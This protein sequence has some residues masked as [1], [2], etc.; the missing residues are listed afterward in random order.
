MTGYAYIVSL[1]MAELGRGAEAM[2]L[3][4]E[5]EPKIPTRIRDLMVA[6]RM[7]LEGNAEESIAAIARV[8]YY[9]NQTSRHCSGAP[10]RRTAP[11][12]MHSRTSADP[13]SWDSATSP[14][15][16]A[17]SRRFFYEECSGHG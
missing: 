13:G 3:L 10:T 8:A 15:R 16:P 7:M 14:L 2:Q 11:P 4:R 12:H 5:L 9:S 1:S 6:A 17:T